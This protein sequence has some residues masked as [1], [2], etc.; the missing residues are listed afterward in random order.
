MQVSRLVRP[1]DAGA[2]AELLR[3]NR[4]F[5]AP[6]SPIRGDGHYTADGQQRDIEDAL[7]RHAEGTA[8]PHVIVDSDGR[9]VGRITLSGIVRGPFLS[10]AMGYWVGKA[11]NGRGFA[12]AAVD[13]IK[14]I[15]FGTLALH[16]IQAETLLHNVKSQ[17][18]LERA[19][20]MRY[21]LAPQYL[22]IA[23]KW[24]DHLLYQV[25]AVGE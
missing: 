7:T 3:A 23:G 9:I 22:K 24:Q 11:D 13:E 5:L 4:E 1:D 18:I 14:R 17:R 10:C 6:W 25:L 19:G 8:L 2:L 12:T 20:F 21:G 15:A 16:R